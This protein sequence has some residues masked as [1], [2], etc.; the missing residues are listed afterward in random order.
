MTWGSNNA[1]VDGAREEVLQA[2]SAEPDYQARVRFFSALRS[3]Y[4][5][6]IYRGDFIEGATAEEA[7]AYTHA[8][9]VDYQRVC[10]WQRRAEADARR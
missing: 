7:V 5:A 1:A 10:E 2:R 4:E 3:A 6:L 9:L 8:F